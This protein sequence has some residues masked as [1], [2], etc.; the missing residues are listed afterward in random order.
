[1]VRDF[2]SVIGREARTQIVEQIGRLPDYLVACVGG[3]SNAM[4]LFYPFKDDRD[5]RMVGVEAGGRGMATGQ[6]AATLV[7][8][9]PGVLHGAFSYLL[10]DGAG[11]VLSTHSVSAGLDYP[12]V[13]PE[14]SYFK[15]TARASYVAV[16]DAEALEGFR[17]LARSEGIIPALEPAHAIAYVKT[18]A[19]TLD[20][21]RVIVMGLSGRGDKDVQHVAKM[22]DA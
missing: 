21:D 5:V 16:T 12:G 10:Q 7:A 13:G 19:P 3:G 15:D 20:R 9:T 1:M 8:G 18:L 11:Q 6:H 2:Q 4:G 17:L 14:H 22:V